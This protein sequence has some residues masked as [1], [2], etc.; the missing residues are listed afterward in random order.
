MLWVTWRQHRA[1]L[2]AAGGFLALMALILIPS[3]LG[4]GSVFEDAGLT[5]CDAT[6]ESCRRAASAFTDRYAGLQFVIPLFLLVP[7]LI[8]LFWGAPLLAREIEQGTHRLAWTQG[9]TRRGWLS[10]K[11]SLLT[12]G[13]MIFGALFSLMLTWWSRP[14]VIAAD[15]GFAPGPFDLRGGV[16]VAHAVFAFA[17]GV[18]AGVLLRRTLPAMLATLAGY[19]GARA[20]VALWLRPRFMAAKTLA[21]P[22]S[23]DSPRA[24]LGDWSIS[25]ATVD[26]AGTVI[27]Q[28]VTFNYANLV[29]RCPD[30][31]APGSGFPPVEAMEACI[32][33]VG[34][35]VRELYHPAERY[36]TFQAI[37][38]AIFIALS[39]ALFAF[40]T[41]R[42]ARRG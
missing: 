12:A 5:T 13:V 19:A 8:G 11:M 4:I 38:S 28:G 36:W 41:H 2:L 17:V 9:V 42:V 33:T 26:R 39:L 15:N 10:A 3:G 31:P 24:G 7:A 25:T 22:M 37:E 34:L 6:Q 16:V 18:V 29:D 30:L 1:Q 23:G 40:A 35:H 27:D 21:Y 14:F 20:A 32:R